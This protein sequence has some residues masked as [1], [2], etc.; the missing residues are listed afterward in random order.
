MMEAIHRWCKTNIPTFELS[1]E[2]KTGTNDAEEAVQEARIEIQTKINY[3]DN[4]G[5]KPV[6]H[7]S[8]RIM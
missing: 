2:R 5:A 7:F 4:A 6:H 3:F 8:G 1:V